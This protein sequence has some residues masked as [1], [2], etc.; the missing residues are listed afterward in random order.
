M[1]VSSDFVSDA[2]TDYRADGSKAVRELNIQGDGDVDHQNTHCMRFVTRGNWMHNN[3]AVLPAGTLRADIRCAIHC[4]RGP[5][6][7]R[8][9][10]YAGRNAHIAVNRTTSLSSGSFDFGVKPPGSRSPAKQS[11]PSEP[12]QTVSAA[13][14]RYLH[15][16]H[17]CLANG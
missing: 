17:G 15:R 7:H 10:T 2:L 1:I 16:R 14:R 6:P 3:A 13:I 5:Y 8:A 12:V 11:K 4:S 9:R